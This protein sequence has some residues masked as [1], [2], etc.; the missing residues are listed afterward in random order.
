MPKR[1]YSQWDKKSLIAHIAKLE[2]RKKYGLVWDEENT[3]EIFEV[4]A[5]NALPVLENVAQNAITSNPKDTTHIV[6]EGD[7]YHALSV[8]SY[9]H[10]GSVDLIFIDPP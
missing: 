9:T 4:R 10:E 2:K 6:I 3:K 8:L 1:D 7:N 5:Q